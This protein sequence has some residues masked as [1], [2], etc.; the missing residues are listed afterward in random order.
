[1]PF[2]LDPVVIS[3]EDTS[4]WL[5]IP[6]RNLLIEAGMWFQCQIRSLLVWMH[7]ELTNLKN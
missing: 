5:W 7:W 3:K 1:V 6:E 4:S 2:C